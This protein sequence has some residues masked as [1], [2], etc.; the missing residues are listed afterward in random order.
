[1]EINLDLVQKYNQPGP[2]Y[3]SYP[4]ATKF[5][6]EVDR[7]SMEREIAANNKTTRDLSLYFHIPFCETLC[8]FCGCTT[9][10]TTQHQQ[11]KPYIE[12]L[13][14][15]MANATQI[16]NPSRKV[17][18]LHFGGGTPTFLAP[19]E[20]RKLGASIRKHF[21]FSPELEAGVEMDPRRLS[22]DHI[23][24]LKEVGFNRASFGVQD[25]NPVVQK[26]VHRIQP[27]EMTRQ[28]IDTAR[29]LG[30]GSINVDLIYGLPYQTVESFEK[31]IDEVMQLAPDR[32]AIFSYAHVP[33]MKPS[34]KILEKALPSAEVKLQMLKMIVEKLSSEGQYDY[35]G[36]DHFARFDDELSI[37]QRNKTLH[38]NFQG[39]STRGGA[40]IYSFG[41][42]SIS[43][44]ENAY[45]QNEKELPNYYRVVDEGRM[46]IMRGYIITADDRIRRE[47]IMRLMCDMELDFALMSQKLGISFKEYFSS[48]LTSFD[49]MVKDGLLALGPDR[50]EV[51]PLG[52]LFIRNI[53]M[54]FDAY[55]S[56][57][58]ERRFSRTI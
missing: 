24:A 30:F 20:I 43:Q 4:P 55:L 36:M 49:E 51:T 42:S 39:Y 1:M 6:V 28:S 54:K 5:T 10:I 57:E 8:W 22:R 50:L 53:A 46:P 16:I 41:M 26:A 18:Q 3:T 58:K 40:D 29:E 32:L 34:Q 47:T 35:I 52:R 13:E 2:R 37:A 56:Q 25:F 11:S 38:R 33:W 12:V 21:T 48:E 31:T 7:A 17:V 14:R 15:E 9:V 23:V 44:I 27:L 45:W 19:D